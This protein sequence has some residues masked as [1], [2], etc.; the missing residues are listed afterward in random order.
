VNKANAGKEWSLHFRERDKTHGWPND[1]WETA[2]N[3]SRADAVKIG[4]TIAEQR[5]GDDGGYW[6]MGVEKKSE[7]G[8]A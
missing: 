1:I 8:A 5:A 2:V 4:K 3:C 7:G 6:F